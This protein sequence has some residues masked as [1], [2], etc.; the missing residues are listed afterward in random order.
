MRRYLSLIMVVSLIISI[1]LV[2]CNGTIN[3]DPN[4]KQGSAVAE[5]A[6]NNLN[7]KGGSLEPTSTQ[8]ISSADV[9]GSGNINKEELTPEKYLEDFEYMYQVLKENYPF[10]DINKRHTG[11][12]WLAEKDTYLQLINNVKSDEDFK[13]ALKRILSD[14]HNGHTFLW[15]G[16][17]IYQQRKTLFGKYPVMYK[18]WLDQLNMQ[19]AVLRYSGDKENVPVSSGSSRNE[20][21]NDSNLITEILDR[22]KTAYIRI[23]QMNTDNIAADMQL[24]RQLFETGNNYRKLI[25]DIRGNGG[26]SDAYWRAYLIPLLTSKPVE[27]SNYI[28]LRGGI[29]EE[30]FVEGKTGSGYEVSRCEVK[31]I[32]KDGLNNLP[33]EILSNFKY[34]YKSTTTIYPK[35]SVNF[36]G[37]IYLLVDQKVY[38]AS[39]G[40]AS[41]AKDTGFATLAG[42]KTGGD[43]IGFDPII[44]TLPNSGY[45]INFPCV[46]GLT[47]KGVCDEDVK[48]EP[49]IYFP[50]EYTHYPSDDDLVQYI[51]KL[52]D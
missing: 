32:S 21:I 22:G 8:D 34:Y 36:E 23:K 18:P 35:D 9:I 47:S 29:F 33:D 42:V 27:F 10:F 44:C 41:F 1:L 45:V 2:G 14:L 15:D 38:S 16:N 3:N 51:I 5:A 43:G 50:T 19:S 4:S 25:I 7:T 40:F 24:V 48:T 6:I 20:T 52:E 13:Y 12:D 37:K 26:G 28:L 39:E 11:I 49:D 31:D 30:P 46:M 17:G